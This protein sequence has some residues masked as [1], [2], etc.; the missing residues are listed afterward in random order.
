M[1]LPTHI[2]ILNVPNVPQIH[3]VLELHREVKEG[4]PKVSIDFKA[5]WS[6]VAF[7]KS[8]PIQQFQDSSEF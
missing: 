7:A 6:V 3:F 8:N 4:K 1:S 2:F 5:S